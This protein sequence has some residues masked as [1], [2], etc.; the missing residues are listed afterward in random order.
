LNIGS[1]E[2]NIYLVVGLGPQN[3]RLDAKAGST[4]SYSSA[5]P[6]PTN[7][8]IYSNSSAPITF[9]NNGKIIGV[10]YAPLAT[11]EVRNKEPDPLDPSNLI[12][13]A[14]S[15]IFANSLVI[16]ADG[17]F[18]YDVA[19]KDKLVSSLISVVSWKEI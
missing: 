17:R 4:I 18:Y 10:V 11:V 16:E 1:G 15:L 14:Y 9:R 6:L 3:G 13:Q 12:A 2:V 7:F 5:E 8:T 19:F